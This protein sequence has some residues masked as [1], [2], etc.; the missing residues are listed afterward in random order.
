MYLSGAKA[1]FPSNAQNL[2]SGVVRKINLAN[3]LI[4]DAADSQIIPNGV[5]DVFRAR[6]KIQMFWINAVF[7]IA[8]M[9]NIIS[10][11]NVS[12]VEEIRKD[13]GLNSNQFSGNSNSNLPIPS[14][15]RCAR[16]Q[17]APVICDHNFREKA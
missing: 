12:P 11:N 8:G 4:S 15:V 5:L 16:K 10:A 2:F 6:S 14:S 9:A 3:L 7:D 17:V 13:V 1:I